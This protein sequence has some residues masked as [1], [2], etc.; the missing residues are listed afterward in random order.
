MSSCKSLLF[1]ICELCAV[2][3]VNRS[4]LE[5]NL[6]RMREAHCVSHHPIHPGSLQGSNS[7]NSDF[8]HA[9]LFHSTALH[10]TVV[11]IGSLVASRLYSCVFPMFMML[12]VLD[13]M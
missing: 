4:Q 11:V 8:P 13:K 12:H 9:Q 2:H 10:V 1:H 6:A 3:S 7:S 5:D